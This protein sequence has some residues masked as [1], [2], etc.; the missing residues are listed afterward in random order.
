[1][2]TLTVITPLRPTFFI[3][4]EM[5]PPISSSP[6]A[7][8][9]ATFKNKHFKMSG[10]DRKIGFKLMY[11]LKGITTNFYVIIKSLFVDGSWL[12]PLIIAATLHLYLVLTLFSGR[13]A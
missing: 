10:L 5:M 8:I 11:S 1:M 7:E 4:F 12:V 13:V 6:L 2:C 9:V 3:A